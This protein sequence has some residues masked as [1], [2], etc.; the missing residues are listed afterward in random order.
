MFFPCSGHGVLT[1][2][3]TAISRC[4]ADT[5]PVAVG[6]QVHTERM[7]QRA[8]IGRQVLQFRVLVPTLQVSPQ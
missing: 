4:P 1:Q 6:Q 2:R 5:S 8:C 7:R 3:K